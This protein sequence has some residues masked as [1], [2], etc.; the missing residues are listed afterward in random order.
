MIL[1]AT[2]VNIKKKARNNIK[3]KRCT[4]GTTTV[5]KLG[6]DDESKYPVYKALFW[7]TSFTLQFVLRDAG[8]GFVYLVPSMLLMQAGA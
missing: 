2:E 6:R 3:A 5:C 1:T 4:D 7:P 8:R